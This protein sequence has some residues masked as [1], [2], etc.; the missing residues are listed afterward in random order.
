MEKDEVITW[1]FTTHNSSFGAIVALWINTFT[2]VVDLS[3]QQT[4]D[5]GEYVVTQAGSYR[6]TAGNFDLNDGYIHIIIE[7]KV[8]N[9]I[10]SYPLLL[11]IGLVGFVILRKIIKIKVIE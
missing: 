1:A 10:S 9:S 2:F 11:M 6:I 8:E 4:S 3:F 5:N 7:N